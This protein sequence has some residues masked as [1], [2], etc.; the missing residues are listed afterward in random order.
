MS[1][2]LHIQQDI[3]YKILIAKPGKKKTN[4][5]ENGAND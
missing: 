1:Q 3:V 4:L 2:S 5:Y